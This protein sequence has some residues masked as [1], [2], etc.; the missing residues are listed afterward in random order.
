MDTSERNTHFRGFAK[1]V[2]RDLNNLAGTYAGTDNADM[3]Q[4]LLDVQEIIAQRAYDL[5][6]HL[7]TKSIPRD[8]NMAPHFM[9]EDETYTE[10]IQKHIARLPDVK[11][12]PHTSASNPTNKELGGNC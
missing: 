4:Y 2:Q 10:T 5:I 12:W 8:L 7:L 9:E 3:Q 11:E 6:W 1:L